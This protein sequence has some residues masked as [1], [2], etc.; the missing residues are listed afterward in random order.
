MTRAE[1]AERFRAHD[2][3][4]LRV[5]LSLV[6]F[7]ASVAVA[8]PLLLGLSFWTP[9]ESE[10][11]I[12]LVWSLCFAALSTLILAFVVWHGRKTARRLGLVCPSCKASLTN[13][14]RQVICGSV[15]VAVPKS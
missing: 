7:V 10:R 6:A 4:W 14:Q 11:P 15:A 5:G 9:L 13:R 1:L 8:G 3:H 12:R 2:R